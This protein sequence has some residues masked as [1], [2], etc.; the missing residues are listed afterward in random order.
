MA[1]NVNN[2]S[3]LQIVS[4]E[5][6]P[7]SLIFSPLKG[8]SKKKKTTSP[9]PLRRPKKSVKQRSPKKSMPAANA[10]VSGICNAIK[11]DGKKCTYKAKCLSKDKKNKYCGVHSKFCA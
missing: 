5:K 1:S 11:A 3:L 8:E 7:C 6:S 9:L 2:N 4:R 10:V